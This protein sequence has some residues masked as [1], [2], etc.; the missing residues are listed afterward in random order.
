MENMEAEAVDRFNGRD[1]LFRALIFIFFL[2]GSLPGKSV[3]SSFIEAP[4]GIE[5]SMAVFALLSLLALAFTG[6][7]V[8]FAL[9]PVC[10]LLAG[11]YV[12][13]LAERIVAGYL[14]SGVLDK[15]ALILCA[16][17]TPGYFVLSHGG[18]RCCGMLSRAFERCGE[19]ARAEYSKAFLPL[20]IAIV[21]MAL[22][23]YIILRL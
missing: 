19:S 7:P 15:S 20:A 11:A 17:F 3:V 23:F 14:D 6:L 9:L 12:G 22:A 13:F 18:L 2:V 10:A 4:P 8:G 21:F 5:I 16:V 1:G